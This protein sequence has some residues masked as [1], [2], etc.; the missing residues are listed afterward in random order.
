MLSLE[1]FRNNLLSGGREF[2]FVI[3][4]MCIIMS[5]F[6]PP[7]SILFLVIAVV[8]FL[9]YSRLKKDKNFLFLLQRDVVLV[10]LAKQGSEDDKYLFAKLFSLEKDKYPVL[11]VLSE[12]HRNDL[13]SAYYE[14]LVQQWK[15]CSILVVDV[16]STDSSKKAAEAVENLAIIKSLPTWKFHAKTESP[17]WPQP[18]KTDG[19]LPATSK[20]G[21]GTAEPFVSVN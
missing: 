14:Y 13:A 20:K 3:S 6:I 12:L 8:S 10:V 5:L 4:A 16:S 15:D 1:E 19:S 21:N 7:A 17:S 11:Q 2:L 9:Y 18:A